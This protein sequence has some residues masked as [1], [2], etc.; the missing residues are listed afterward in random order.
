MPGIRAFIALPSDD[1]IT[2][3]VVE[4]QQELSQVHAEVRWEPTDKLHITLKFLGE[5]EKGV[6]EELHNSL[7]KEIRPIISSPLELTYSTLGVFPNPTNA[8][9]IWIGADPDQGLLALCSCVEKVSEGFGFKREDRP[10]HPHLTIGRVKG[11]RNLANLTERLKTI[12]LEPV[13]SLCTE[14]LIMQ[15]QLYPAGSRYSV[16]K[17]IPLI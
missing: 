9:V 3:K 13:K 10:F 6:L 1:V 5:T 8:R 12:T 4:L 15:S 17:T 16:V 2:A 14:I 11:R 7:V